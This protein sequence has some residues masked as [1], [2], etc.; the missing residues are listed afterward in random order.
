MFFIF[1]HE[2][3]H[4]SLNGKF[5]R[6]F[7]KENQIQS[8]QYRQSSIK[9]TQN[10]QIGYKTKSNVTATHFSTEMFLRN[11][12]LR[13]SKESH[14]ISISSWKEFPDIQKSALQ[15]SSLKAFKIIGNQSSGLSFCRIRR[16]FL[17]C[18]IK[19]KILKILKCSLSLQVHKTVQINYFFQGRNTFFLDTFDKH[20]AKKFFFLQFFILYFN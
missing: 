20:L 7:L 14:T 9:N 4:H 5:K 17:Y 8:K 1:S 3:L 2:F 10:S 18:K 13:F 11:W 16:G 19:Y 15:F 12:V 6:T